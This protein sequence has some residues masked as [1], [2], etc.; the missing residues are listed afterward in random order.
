MS[1]FMTRCVVLCEHAVTPD[2]VDVDGALG[3]DDE[4]QWVEAAREAYQLEG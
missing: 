4:A 3:D 1:T 2:A